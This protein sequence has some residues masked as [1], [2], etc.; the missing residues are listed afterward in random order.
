MLWKSSPQNK[1]FKIVWGKLWRKGS[2]STKSFVFEINLGEPMHYHHRPPPPLPW[3]NLAQDK[4]S[5][6][7][8]MTASAWFPSTVVFFLLLLFKKGEATSCRSGDCTGENQNHNHLQRSAILSQTFWHLKSR[9]SKSPKT[10][11]CWFIINWTRRWIRQLFFYQ[12]SM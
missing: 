4:S 5:L 2:S 11:F 3:P 6:A 7:Q 8:A 1:V 9:L 12:Y 10:N